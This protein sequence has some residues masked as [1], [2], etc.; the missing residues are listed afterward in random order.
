MNV[1]KRQ[2]KKLLNCSKKSV[3]FIDIDPKAKKDVSRYSRGKWN[4]KKSYTHL[5]KAREI[6]YQFILDNSSIFR[7]EK[8]CNI[9]GIKRNSYY[10]WLKRPPSER[11]L[12][13]EKLVKEIKR[14]H[15]E[16]RL[17]ENLRLL[18]I[19]ITTII[20]PLI[21]LNKISM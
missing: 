18:L 2:E 9:L 11:Q 6:K 17:L 10:A 8:M 14:V 19:L 12:N 21:Y 15:K 5:H 7:V 16:V 4:I 13:D 3:Y 20:L 1:K